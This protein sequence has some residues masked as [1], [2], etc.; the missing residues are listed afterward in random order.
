MTSR[1]FISSG[2][3]AGLSAGLSTGAALGALVIATPAFAQGQYGP[4]MTYDDRGYEYAQPASAAV[5]Q[6]AP[7]TYRQQAVVQPLPQRAARTT[8]VRYIKDRPANHAGA[9]YEVEYEAAPRVAAVPQHHARRAVPAHAPQPVMHH[10]M[11]HNQAAYP[12]HHQQ[13]P[14]FDRQ[15]WLD[16]CVDRVSGGRHD[17]RD[18]NGNVIGGLVGAAAGG[19]IG[20]RVA[21]RGNR[22]AGGLIGAGVG[23]LAGLA[24]GAAIDKSSK[25]GNGDAYAY[26]EDYLARYSHGQ[27]GYG[28]QQHG[29][30]YQY[31]R[32]MMLVPVW[33]QVPQRAVTREYVTHEYVDVEVVEYETVPARRV[34]KRAPAPRPVKRIKVQQSKPVRYRK[35]K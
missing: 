2:I 34:I 11:P 20:N 27:G 22:L 8:P 29:Y 17:R 15:A 30:A 6:A 10:P 4:E 14:R 33:V 24:V 3:S 28:Y 25:R 31:A 21:G 12:A 18:R 32:P 26:C 13:Q 9:D 23:G 19:L 1:T 35:G 16:E 7:I 5:P